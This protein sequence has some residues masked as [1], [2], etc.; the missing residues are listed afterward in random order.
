MPIEEMRGTVGN[1]KVFGSFQNDIFEILT[2]END[3]IEPEV[4]MPKELKKLQDRRKKLDTLRKAFWKLSPKLEK[5]YEWLGN[6]IR[7]LKNDESMMDNAGEDDDS[8]EVESEISEELENYREAWK[9]KIKNIDD[10]SKEKIIKAAENIKVNEKIDSDGSRLIEFKVWWKKWKILDPI[11]NNHTDDEYRWAGSYSSINEI[12]R[13]EVKLWWMKWDDVDNWQ[14]KKLAKYVKQKQREWLHIAKIEEMKDLLGKLW[15]EAGL[16]KEDD[17]IAMLMYLTGMYW[18]YR[19]SM[20]DN[21]SSN[22]QGD[23]RSGLICCADSR[24]FAYFNYDGI[25]ASLCMIA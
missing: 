8:P 24:L 16:D 25:N 15:A 22:S 3:D 1:N 11:L 23:S 21:K 13:N 18:R 7:I 14:N 9:D 19:L 10:E 12:T 6:R 5:E 17:Q 20:W 2:S 4:E